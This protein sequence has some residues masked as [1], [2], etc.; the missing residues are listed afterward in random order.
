M[1]SATTTKT[2]S[3]APP[4][5]MP[6]S[7]RILLSI[8]YSPNRKSRF[9]E[10]KLL[11]L[12]LL[13]LSARVFLFIYSYYAIILHYMKICNGFERQWINIDVFF[14]YT[15]TTIN[16]KATQK[17]FS[18]FCYFYFFF[19]LLLIWCFLNLFP[20]FICVSFKILHSFVRIKKIL[21]LQIAKEKEPERAGWTWYCNKK[22][23]SKQ[24]I[25]GIVM[26]QFW[27]IIAQWI[28]T[29]FNRR[30]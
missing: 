11:L 24:L 26:R 25:L 8:C 5:C 10:K 19:S 4:L 23:V 29:H 9:V 13:F 15:Y 27:I 30:K 21:P 1:N 28:C 6:R 12:L 2:L 14:F 22:H 3:L 7:Q 18:F 17:Y 20:H 16:Q